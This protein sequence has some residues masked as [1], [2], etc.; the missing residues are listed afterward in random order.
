MEEFRLVEQV[1]DGKPF[2]IHIFKNFND[3]YMY[4]LKLIKLQQGSVR[5]KYYVTNSFFKNKYPPFVEGIKKYTIEVREVDTW[6]EY[7]EE[8][9]SNK[10]IDKKVI[11]F[12]Y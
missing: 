5:K 6:R 11:P 1:G 4:L 7:V 12:K 2:S 3:C 8:K 9:S 10:S